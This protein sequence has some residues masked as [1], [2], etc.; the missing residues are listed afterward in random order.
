MNRTLSKLALGISLVIVAVPADVDGGGAVAAVG[1][2]GGRR[3]LPRRGRRPDG[4]R[5]HEPLSLIQPADTR[6]RASPA[7]A[8]ANRNPARRP[9]PPQP[10]RATPIATR[11]RRPIAGAAARRRGLRQSQPERGPPGSCRAARGYANRNQ[12]AVLQRRRRRRRRGLR[13]SQPE[14]STPTRVPPP[15][16]RATPTATRAQYPNAGAAA[17]GAGYALQPFRH[18][19]RLLERQQLRRLGATGLGMGYASGVGAWGAGSP[20]YGWGYSGYS[21]PYYGGGSGPAAMRRPSARSSPRRAAAGRGAGLQLLPADQHDRRA[22]RAGRRRPGDLGLRPGPRGVQDGRLRPGPAA[23][24][25]GTRPDAQRHD[26]AR[27]PRPG[28]TSP[29][30]STSRPRRRSTPSSRCGPVGTGRP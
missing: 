14:P 5:L 11:S 6:R 7:R 15:S 12:S 25:A 16:A 21:N 17:A 8:P 1:G 29:R 23:R 4:G 2:G 13:Q 28:A 26:D 18:G 9:A 19:Q 27:V 20:M 24:P 30:A 3:R 10:E 22:A